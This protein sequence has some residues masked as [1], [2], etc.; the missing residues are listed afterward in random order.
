MH[1]TLER[2]AINRDA[3]AIERKRKL[4]QHVPAA[5]CNHHADDHEEQHGAGPDV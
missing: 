2:T 3:V 5:D 4:A 1:R